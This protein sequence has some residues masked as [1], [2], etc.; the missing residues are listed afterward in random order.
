MGQQETEVSWACNK[1]GSGA[2]AVDGNEVHLL[3]WQGQ[4]LGRWRWHGA[5]GFG[6]DVVEG[7]GF[8]FRRLL[9]FRALRALYTLGWRGQ[10]IGAFPRGGGHLSYR[11]TFG[12]H[13][14]LA[15]TKAIIG[16]KWLLC[17][18]NNESLPTS[19]PLAHFMYLKFGTDDYKLFA[20]TIPYTKCS[21]YRVLSKSDLYIQDGYMMLYEHLLHII[22]N[23]HWNW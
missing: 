13:R 22:L 23:L 18:C 21:T 16:L 19:A 12:T 2:A 4:F 6:R 9:L 15:E 11:R 3:G 14:V 8:Y 7:R 20:Y 17:I 5:G 1:T 10:A